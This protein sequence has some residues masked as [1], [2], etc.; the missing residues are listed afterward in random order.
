M[1]KKV[2]AETMVTADRARTTIKSKSSAP[3]RHTFRSVRNM[4]RSGSLLLVFYFIVALGSVF[5]LSAMSDP[6]PWIHRV[7]DTVTDSVR[8][9]IELF[10]RDLA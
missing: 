5:V 6:L 9:I 4:H 3:R 8:L 2:E 10:A 1:L 7:G